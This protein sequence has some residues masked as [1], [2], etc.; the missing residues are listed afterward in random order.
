MKEAHNAG[1]SPNQILITVLAVVVAINILTMGFFTYSV[2]SKLNEAIDLTKP[3]KA[4][5]TLV[6]ADD[7]PLCGDLVQYKNV[8]KAQNVELSDDVVVG[9]NSEEGKQ[10]IKDLGLTRL[11]A[12]VFVTDENLKSEIAKTLEK[13]SRRIGENTIVWEKVYPPY[14]DIQTKNVSGLVDV[15]YITDKRCAN[16]YDPLQI[17]RQ[18][19]QNYGVVISSE[20]VVD[21][22]DAVG[23]ELVSKYNIE[24]VPTVLLFGTE[25]YSTFLNIWSQVGTIEDD[26]MLVFRKPEVLN[27]T[28]KNLITG[29]VIEPLVATEL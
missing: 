26:G 12:L 6:R 18:V 15:I 13:D 20:K 21:V 9:S 29:V 2:N 28:Y 1:R 24:Q 16:C 3:Q 17:H 14:L 5:L 8:V 11:P 22:L 4:K 27:Q 7:C 23:N 19:L 10:L 25:N